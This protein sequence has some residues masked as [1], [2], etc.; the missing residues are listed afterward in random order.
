MN[1]TATL[2][3]KR[4]SESVV[5]IQD[6]RGI[7]KA[8]E[9]DLADFIGKGG[10]IVSRI[11]EVLENAPAHKS[12]EEWIVMVAGL[13]VLIS[14]ATCLEIAQSGEGDLLKERARHEILNE[15]FLRKLSSESLALPGQ[16]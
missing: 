8:A 7:L 3:L 4:A 6:L 9:K 5:L 10:S 13:R 1:E 14:Q 2:D 15:D 12:V 16:R 11:D